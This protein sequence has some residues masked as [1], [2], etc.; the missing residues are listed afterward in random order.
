MADGT[1]RRVIPV[2]GSDMKQITN[3]VRNFVLGHL[4]GQTCAVSSVERC[5]RDHVSISHGV[6]GLTS[7]HVVR[8]LQITEQVGEVQLSWEELSRTTRPG[9]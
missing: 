8:S 6:R 5:R 7:S 2:K 4:S 1:Q 3:W 9:T